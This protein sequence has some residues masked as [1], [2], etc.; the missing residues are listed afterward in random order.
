MPPIWSP[1]I[2]PEPARLDIPQIVLDPVIATVTNVAEEEN[3][4]EPL[5]YRDVM[6]SR[7]SKEWT[8]AIE[9]ELAAIAD[10]GTWVDAVA[11][12]G[13]YPLGHKW[14]FKTK[15]DE[16]GN[17]V[18]HKARIVA[19]GFRQIPGLHFNDTFSPVARLT[20]LRILLTVAADEDLEIDQM[21][22]DSAFL[23]GTLKETIYMKMPEGYKPSDPNSNCVKLLKT[24]YGLKQ[25]SREWWTV[26][27]SFL[28][29]ELSMTRYQN[30]W[31]IYGRT[32]TEGKGGKLYI[33]VYVDDLLIVGGREDVDAAKAK[34]SAKWS[35]TDYGP[36]RH[37]LGL[38]VRRK[39]SNRTLSISQK[40][41][42]DQLL[43]KYGQ[44]NA[45]NVTS[46]I[47]PGLRMTRRTTEEPCDK[48]LYPSV[49]GSLMW[50]ALG[51]RPDIAF[52]VNY[53]GRYNNDPSVD[54]W[55]TA[56]RSLRYLKATRAYKLDLGRIEGGRLVGFCDSDWAGDLDDRKSTTGYLFKYRG[57]PISWGSRKQTTTASSTAEAEYMALSD[58]TKEALYLRMLL[59]EFGNI[60]ETATTIYCDNQGA[61]ALA[62][63]PSQHR[64]TKHIDI[65]Y[66]LIREHVDNGFISVQ[67]I[68]SISNTADIFTK[69]LPVTT[70]RSHIPAIGL[71]DD[72]KGEEIKE[73]IMAIRSEEDCWN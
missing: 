12:A 54:H 10:K 65:R 64:K 66:H 30:D 31:G 47:E 49:V 40:A 72:R 55:R 35:M 14:V 52:T 42:V 9:R 6:K 53:L 32:G 63:N 20:S 26:I 57:A 56:M 68:S 1:V 22:V 45:N 8:A 50:L 58:A 19:Q 39:R 16:S 43:E 61:I 38:H 41:Y 24:L 3:D 62:N 34:L 18:K 21:D 7:C 36:V 15:R 4:E 37:I 17:I 5:S 25:S 44:L 33:L 11:P 67:H 13:T 51:T 59:K 69:P 23:N 70:F 73:D 28:M 46:P 48:E 60:S 2:P 29:A 27:S 71:R